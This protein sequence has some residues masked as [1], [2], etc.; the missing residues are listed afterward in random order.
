MYNY[1]VYWVKIR[2]EGAKFFEDLMLFW[3][4]SPPCFAT[5]LPKTM[6]FWENSPLF[7]NIFRNLRSWSDSAAGEIWGF[8]TVFY[9]FSFKNRDFDTLEAQNFRLRRL[10]II[11]TSVSSADFGSNSIASE[12]C[13]C[14][15]S[16]H[17]GF[18]A[19]ILSIHLG[20]WDLYSFDT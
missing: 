12:I 14:I 18:W 1:S 2:A 19:C 8:G 17:L 6:V 10:H 20:F 11:T 9:W 3:E 7:R 5:F 16:I 15:L 4:N 13:V